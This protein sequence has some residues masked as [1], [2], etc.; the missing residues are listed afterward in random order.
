MDIQN[1]TFYTRPHD[2]QS[3]LAPREVEKPHRTTQGCRILE[4]HIQKRPPPHPPAPLRHDQRHLQHHGD[5]A[6]APQLLGDAGEDE[7]VREGA[8]EEGEGRG[9]WPRDDGARGRVDVAPEEVVHGYVP[10]AGELEP[11]ARVP[12]VFVEVAVGEA[13]GGAIGRVSAISFLSGVWGWGWGW[14]VGTYR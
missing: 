5:G 1:S 4:T 7:L 12:P 3:V 10:L 14:G 8:D 2:G 9:H 6:V 13:C 11:V